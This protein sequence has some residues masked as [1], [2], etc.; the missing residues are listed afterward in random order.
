VGETSKQEGR[1]QHPQ[2]SPL[3]RNSCHRAYN[4]VLMTNYTLIKHTAVTKQQEHELLNEFLPSELECCNELLL[5]YM[6]S[7]KEM[8]LD[9][10]R[11]LYPPLKPLNSMTK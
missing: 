11:S 2:S 1:S 4:L 10:V 8:F 3:H 9:S 5:L 6:F 7:Y